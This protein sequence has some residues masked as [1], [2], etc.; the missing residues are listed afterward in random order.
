VAR[1]PSTVHC[2]LIR[3]ILEVAAATAT[4]RGTVCSARSSCD[5]LSSGIWCLPRQQQHP[6]ICDRQAFLNIL[7]INTSWLPCI[8]VTF[9]PQSLAAMVPAHRT[10]NIAPVF[11]RVFHPLLFNRYYRLFTLLVCYGFPIAFDLFWFICLLVDRT[12]LPSCFRHP[13]STI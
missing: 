10:A 11:C 3:A 5:D 13:I 7:T 8:S 4:G 12:Y 1:R 9:V 2:R 6:I